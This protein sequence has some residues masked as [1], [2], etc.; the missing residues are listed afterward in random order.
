MLACTV[1]HPVIHV[2]PDRPS[3]CMA[4]EE[5]CR[6]GGGS[7]SGFGAGRLEPE[8][9]EA[10]RAFFTCQPDGDRA[11]NRR[12]RSGGSGGQF[13]HCGHFRGGL[14]LRLGLGRSGEEA[15]PGGSQTRPC[16]PGPGRLE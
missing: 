14:R 11:D 4:A 2:K 10:D 3:L 13:R 1:L 6:R 8:A 5:G 12:D 16:K 15:Q 7:F 9:G